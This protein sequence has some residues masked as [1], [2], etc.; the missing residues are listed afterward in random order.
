[1]CKRAG[2]LNIVC[3][4]GACVLPTENLYAYLCAPQ[5]VSK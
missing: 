4:F 3:V 2:V 1:M 5:T